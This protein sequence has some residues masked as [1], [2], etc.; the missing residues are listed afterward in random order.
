[1]DVARFFFLMFAVESHLDFN[2]D[3]AKQQNEKNPVYYVQY[4]HARIASILKK[5]SG[6]PKI[7]KTEPLHEPERYL[8][9]QLQRWPEV[10]EDVSRD[11][12][13]HR[14]PQYALDLA[15]S[16]HD[17]Y[18]QVRV[19]DKDQVWP[20]RLQLIRATKNVLADVLDVLGIHA[21]VKM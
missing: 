17:F 8:I 5:V 20:M 12:A 10:L 2:L 11:L 15:R 21:P 6:L 14:I 9:L 1:L 19:I 18:T 4:A 3:L 16:F 7:K 13:V